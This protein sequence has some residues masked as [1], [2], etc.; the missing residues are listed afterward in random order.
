MSKNMY[1]RLQNFIGRNNESIFFWGARQTGK[2][3]LLKQLFPN[4]VYYDL[5]LSEEYSR[6]M[7]NP[8]LLREEII[9][10]DKKTKGPVIIDE[11][12]RSPELLNEIHWLIVNKGASFILCGSSP[13]KLVRSGGNLLGGRA[14]RY[15]LY[16]LVS[17]EIPDFNLLR[18]LNHGLLPRHY[19]SNTPE[20]MLSSYIS[21]YLKEEIAAEA[22][23]RKVPSFACFLDASAFSNGEVVNYQNIAAECGVSSPTV[24]EYFQILEDTLIARFLP[25]F[26]KRPKRRV[27]QSPKFYFFDVAVANHLLKRGPVVQHGE[28]FGKAFEHFI[29]QEIWAHSK[30]SG[31]DYPISYWRTSSQF[32]VDFIL[33]DHQVAVEVKGT[34]MATPHHCKGLRVFAQE[35]KTRDLILVTLDPRP[36]KID[37][38][39]VLPWKYFL[40]ELWSG[41]IMK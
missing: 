34:N 30:Y 17:A 14:L 6:F 36:R 26:Q 33:G 29:Y 10:L 1:K 20:K 15:D 2:S 24:K 38:V 41:G 18:A 35:Y 28:S 7:K 22:L 9:A 32:E 31:Q 8:G 5:L 4:A 3:T 23:V 25:S 21:N 19:I 27:I 37:N 40:D 13:R 39:R 12:Q 11:I 16:P